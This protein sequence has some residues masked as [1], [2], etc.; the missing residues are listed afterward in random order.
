MPLMPVRSRIASNSA[1]LKAAAP[2]ADSFLRGRSPSGQCL[3][4]MRFLFGVWRFQT[5]F[6]VLSRQ[7]FE[8]R[9][10]IGEGFADALGI[11]DGNGHAQQ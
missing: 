3:M 4:L 10:I 7:R 9:E 5:A 2:K 8:Y 6:F 11:V 1:S